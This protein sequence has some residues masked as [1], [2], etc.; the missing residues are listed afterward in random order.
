MFSPKEYG[1]INEN[2]WA[3]TQRVHKK[4]KPVIKDIV[5]R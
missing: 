1:N 4:S 3:K 2:T 5:A